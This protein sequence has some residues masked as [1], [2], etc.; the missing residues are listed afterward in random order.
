MQL[1]ADDAADQD[2]PTV[3]D[4]AVISRRRGVSVPRWF[5][6][7]GA[8]LLIAALGFGIGWWVTPGD[9]GSSRSASQSTPSGTGAPSTAAPSP[10]ASTAPGAS[11]LSNVGLRE[12]DLG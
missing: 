2:Q 12:S 3:A 4:G 11:A 8:V 1:E 6:V 5:A 7:T 10:P 9:N